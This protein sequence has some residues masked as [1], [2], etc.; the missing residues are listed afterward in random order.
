MMCSRLCVLLEK[1]KQDSGGSVSV[2]EL[3][4]FQRDLH[5]AGAVWSL[6]CRT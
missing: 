4:S 1:P 3:V 2:A 5:E 6:H